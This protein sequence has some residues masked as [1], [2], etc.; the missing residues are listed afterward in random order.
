MLLQ[1]GGAEKRL[2]QPKP[3]APAGKVFGLINNR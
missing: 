2:F 1:Q 3:D